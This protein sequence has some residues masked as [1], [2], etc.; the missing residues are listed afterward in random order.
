[1]VDQGDSSKKINL[2]GGKD[3]ETWDQ[4]MFREYQIALAGGRKFLLPL[5]EYPGFIAP[6]EEGYHSFMD[7]MRV[8]S[9]RGEQLNMTG[10][11]SQQRKALMRSIAIPGDVDHVSVDI[12]RKAIQEARD[13]GNVDQIVAIYH[14]HPRQ[15]PF[16][17]STLPELSESRSAYS[18][19]DLYSLVNRV[20]SLAMAG[21]VEGA[22]NLLVF[23][24]RETVATEVDP[25]ITDFDAFE[26]HWFETY[27]Y[28]YLGSASKLHSKRARA[29]SKNADLWQ[30]NLGI[31][32]RHRLVVYRGFSRQNLERVFP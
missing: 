24:S 6:S 11:D 16:L 7:Q 21:L 26:R 32:A 9:E 20:D 5:R 3:D 23:K 1:M 31:A 2:E 14:S 12:I 10:V 4:N 19:G 25:L 27:G 13:T 29:W 8:E 22:D 30:M 17:W 18:P 15:L 28:E